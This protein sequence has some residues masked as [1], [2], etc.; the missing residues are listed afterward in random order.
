MGAKEVTMEIERLVDAIRVAA[1]GDARAG[2]SR[3][4]GTVSWFC[5]G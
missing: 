5:S 1:N 4:G 3:I 2:S